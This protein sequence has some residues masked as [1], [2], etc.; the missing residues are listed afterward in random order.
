M[1]P[2]SGYL[3]IGFQADNPGAWLM[4]CHIGWHISEGMAL[5]V[6]ERYSEIAALID[7]DI[8]NSTCSAW[9]TYATTNSIVED[10][11]GV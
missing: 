2:S 7:Y 3:V 10:D 8:L 11:S 4:H 1:L 9:E 6:V 5:Q